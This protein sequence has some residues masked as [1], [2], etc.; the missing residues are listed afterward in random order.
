[1][2]GRL[3]NAKCPAKVLSTFLRDL[4]R[5]MRGIWFRVVSASYQPL[6]LRGPRQHLTAQRVHGLRVAGVLAGQ[7]QVAV[8]G[9]V[10]SVAPDGRPV[11]A[12]APAID[13]RL[14]FGGGL[15]RWDAEP[16]AGHRILA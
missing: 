15:F 3:H 14:R 2:A 7:Q 16:N 4:P 8:N 12:R 5:I 6:N 11:A 10:A 9:I 1:M 13:H